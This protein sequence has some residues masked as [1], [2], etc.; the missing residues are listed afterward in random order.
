MIEITRSLARQLRA[1]LRKAS[2]AGALR[3]QRPPLVFHAGPDGLC[4]RAHGVE[5]AAEFRLP[6]AR[7]AAVVSL[8]GAALED[9]ESRQDALVTLEETEPGTTQARWEDGGVPQARA[10]TSQN[11]DKL[12]PFPTEPGTW[13]SA[14]PGLLAALDAAAHTAA[15]DNVRYALTHLQLR[16]GAGEIVA[17]DGKQLLVQGGFT[18]P[19]RDDALIPALTVLG[20]SELP[21]G[22]AVSIGR[23]DTYVGLRVGAWTFYL[24]DY[25]EGRF[26][27]TQE[28]I[29]ALN[30][31]FTTCGLAP[32]DATCLARALPRLPGREDDSSPVTVD[33]HGQPAVRARADGQTGVTELALNRSEVTGPPVRFVCNRQ[34]LARALQLGFTELCVTQPGVPVVCR[35]GNRTYL[36]M[37]LDPGSALPPSTDAVRLA[38]AGDD[39]SASPPQAQPERKSAA[40]TLPVGNGSG[41]GE[42]RGR[43]HTPLPEEGLLP[44]AGQPNEDSQSPPTGS[45][46]VIEEAQALTDALRDAYGRSSRLLAAL[47]RQRKQSKLLQGTLS[48]LKQLQDIGA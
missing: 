24:A 10:Y 39:Q 26:P 30:G 37:P 17:T 42:S 13:T 20:S 34:Y 4:V 47:K 11:P 5:V 19:W 45:G 27:K 18:F 12:A 46:S 32:E 2:C 35:D 15:R 44:A 28:V 38:S 29:P 25:S 23:T 3:S 43:P 16:G 41:H 21:K 14:A 8:P 48:A 31:R 40:R 22:G 7:P 6:G 1:V 36:W 33:F 9:I